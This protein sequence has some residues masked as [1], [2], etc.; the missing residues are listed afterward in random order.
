MLVNKLKREQE[1]ICL[2]LKKWE[3]VAKEGG[4]ETKI[5][6]W[7]EAGSEKT[8][9]GKMF[10]TIPTTRLLPLAINL[11]F[12]PQRTVFVFEPWKSSV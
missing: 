9:K 7:S 12:G 5:K 2:D 11:S 1:L 10:P 6:C 3:M 8:K 4:C